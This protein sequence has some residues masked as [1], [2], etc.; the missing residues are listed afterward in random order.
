MKK[1]VDGL[2]VDLTPQEIEVLSLEEIALLP[3]KV[4]S[5]RNSLLAQSD[6]YALADRLT[7]EWASDRQALRDITAQEGFPHD[8]T[9]PTKPAF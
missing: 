6:V 8:V 1:L 3:I 4:R 9:W 2:Y 5:L 7:P